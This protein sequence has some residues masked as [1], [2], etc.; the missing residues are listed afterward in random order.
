MSFQ[1][2]ICT[3]SLGRSGAGHTLPTKIAAAARH[4]LKGLEIFMEDLLALADTFPGG[5]SSSFPNQVSAASAVRHL[6]DAH[7]LAVICLQPFMHYEGLRD[8]AAHRR[9]VDELR[10]YVALAHVLETDLVLIPSTFLG[11]EELVAAGPE[12]DVY[13][14]MVRDLAEAADVGARAT[15]PV[16]FAYEALCWG[17]RVDTWE[18][19]WEVVRRVGRPNFGLCIDTF[20]LAGRVYADPAS[21][22]ARTAGCEREMKA[23]V[24]RLLR[25]VDP[26]KVFLVQ[27]ADAAE[28]AGLVP[29][30]RLHV[31]GQPARMSWS[32]T[33]RLFYGEGGRGAYL[34]VLQ[35][36]GA[37]V[38]GLGYKGWLSFE[39]FNSELMDGD[40]MLPD[41]LAERAA[42]SWGVMM[43]D[44]AQA[45]VQMREL[46]SSPMTLRSAL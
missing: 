18:R 24:D 35:V 1:P 41:Q 29:G 21:V 4:G 13:D 2:G 31:D 10:R 5:G 44:L 37:V 19:S 26:A 9:R 34:P 12:G 8:R 6:C 22:T 33:S 36:L 28:V 32:R 42:Q 45:Q 30:H 16:R 43:R 23:S 46:R 17:T 38:H 27:V 20:N 14:V 7:G 39:V 3:V 40:K 25:W 11:A 15:P